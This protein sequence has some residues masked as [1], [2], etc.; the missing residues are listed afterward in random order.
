MRYLSLLFLFITV[1]LFSCLGKIHNEG[2]FVIINRSSESIS[3]WGF[4]RG[5][6]IIESGDTSKVYTFKIEN[7]NYRWVRIHVSGEYIDYLGDRF[8]NSEYPYSENVCVREGE[9]TFIE[10]FDVLDESSITIINQT[11]SSI[12]YNL[13]IYRTDLAWYIEPGGNYRWDFNAPIDGE[14]YFGIYVFE[15]F[16]YDTT[17]VVSGGEHLS[18]NILPN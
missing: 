15:P 11:N 9:K 12:S 7:D 18:V 6:E 10:I 13:D 5:T 1:L 3:I 8:N 4:D 14:F 16:F 2:Y 17:V